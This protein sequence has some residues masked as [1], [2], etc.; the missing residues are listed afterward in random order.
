[1]SLIFEM[2]EDCVLMNKSIQDDLYGG[3][4]VTAWTEGV[5]FK[6]SI[7]KNATTE[8][9]I[10]ERQGIKELFTVVVQKGF[11]L[12]FHDVFKRVSDQEVFRVTSRVVDSEAPARSTVKIAKV[13]AEKWELTDEDNGQNS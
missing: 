13:T 1:M 9:L 7:I 12:D 6:A 8:A 3:Y 10:A 11:T 2:M 5:H 4:G